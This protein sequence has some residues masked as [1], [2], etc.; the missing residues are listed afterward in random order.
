MHLLKHCNFEGSGGH[1]PDLMVE[2][3]RGLFSQ[4]PRRGGHAPD[5]M[6]ECTLW[7]CVGRYEFGGHAPDLMVECT[8][9]DNQLA[10]DKA[11][12]PPI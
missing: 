8:H 5:L 10:A 4:P 9:L 1:A 7:G 11:D 2:C 3:T 6:V 12:T